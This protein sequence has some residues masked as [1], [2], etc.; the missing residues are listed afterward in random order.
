MGVRVVL[1]RATDCVV[2][3]FLC[4]FSHALRETPHPCEAMSAFT[5]YPAMVFYDTNCWADDVGCHDIGHDNDGDD[6]SCDGIVVVAA[7]QKPSLASGWQAGEHDEA[8]GE[9]DEAEGEH[10]EA[11]GER[12]E[13]KGE[14]DEAE[15]EHDEGFRKGMPVFGVFMGGEPSRPQLHRFSASRRRLTWSANF[16]ICAGI[17]IS[18][19]FHVGLCCFEFGFCF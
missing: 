6:S 15:G 11:E 16:P 13:A 10:D 3:F 7:S 8:E 4:M 2:V 1:I 18:V 9:H 19:Q 12:D 17:R 14:R 5:P